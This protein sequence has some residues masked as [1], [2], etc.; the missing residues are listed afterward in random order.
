[1]WKSLPLGFLRKTRQKF[2][3]SR[4]LQCLRTFL[5]TPMPEIQEMNPGI[6]SY[7]DLYK[8]SIEQV[9]IVELIANDSALK[10]EIS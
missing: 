1:M 2:I 8:F 9:M 10:T 4:Q 5:S 3:T 6:K 7:A